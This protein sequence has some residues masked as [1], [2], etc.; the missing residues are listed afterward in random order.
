MTQREKDR[1]QI[2][3]KTEDFLAKG[4]KI[5]VLKHRQEADYRPVGDFKSTNEV[6]V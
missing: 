6:Y 2:S 5:E 3:Q 1:I 4:G